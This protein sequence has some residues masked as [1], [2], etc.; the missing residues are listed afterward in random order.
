MSEWDYID[1][2]NLLDH[3]TARE[4]YKGGTIA[5]RQLIAH[6]NYAI[7]DTTA[8]TGVDENGEPLPPAYYSTAYLPI[9]ANI[10]NYAAVLITTEQEMI[11]YGNTAGII[12]Q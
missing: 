10:N 8:D 12:C 1:H 7:Y 6:E 11:D 5:M 2:D 3:I 9:T 4:H